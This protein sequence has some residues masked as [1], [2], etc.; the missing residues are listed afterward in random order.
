MR[1]LKAQ[2]EGETGLSIDGNDDVM[3]WLIRWAGELVTKFSTGKDWKIAQER[4]KG[5]TSKKPMARLGEYVLYLPLD[6]PNT[7]ES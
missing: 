1:T 4:L 6:A 7:E 5:N 3:S 2:L